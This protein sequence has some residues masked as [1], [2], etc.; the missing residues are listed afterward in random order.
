VDAVSEAITTHLV[1][2]FPISTALR[3]MGS[4]VKASLDGRWDDARLA[5]VAGS[6]TLD[7]MQMLRSKALFG[8]AVGLLA[9]DRFPEAGDGR[10]EGEAFFRERG[11]GWLV[12]TYRAKAIVPAGAGP[13]GVPRL[14][15][16]GVAADQAVG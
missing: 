12:D 15:R 8:M 5:F 1:D 14:D 9:G 16:S 4:S 3:L 10:R 2:E 11:A 6:R 7:S 13:A